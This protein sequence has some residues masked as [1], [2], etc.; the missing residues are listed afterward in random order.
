MGSLTLGM[1]KAW[2]TVR[3]KSSTAFIR[4]LHRQLLL[5]EFEVDLS[6]SFF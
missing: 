2:D 4:H 6:T 1:P 3:V 5:W